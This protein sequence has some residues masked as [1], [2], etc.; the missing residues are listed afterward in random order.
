MI[1][2]LSDQFTRWK[3]AIAIP[4]GT[5]ETIANKLDQRVFAY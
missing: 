5:T 3:D 4:N 1:L 2:V